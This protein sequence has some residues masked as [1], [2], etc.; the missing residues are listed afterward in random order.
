ME[1]LD[2]LFNLLWELSKNAN[3]SF[4]TERTFLLLK[5]NL[6]PAQFSSVSFLSRGQPFV[7]P[8]N[9]SHSSLG[10]GTMNPSLCW[11]FRKVNSAFLCIGGKVFPKTHTMNSQ[12]FFW[13]AILT[14]FRYLS[15]QNK[16]RTTKANSRKWTMNTQHGTH[17]FLRTERNTAKS[18]PR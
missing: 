5:S 2:Y 14:K 1:K 15:T 16:T 11:L 10:G 9:W 6:K 17:P 13:K 3:R 18:E 7:L 8:V 4:Y 12:L